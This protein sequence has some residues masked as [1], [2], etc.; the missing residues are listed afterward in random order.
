MSYLYHI[1]SSILPNKRTGWTGWIQLVC[2]RTGNDYVGNSK[3]LQGETKIWIKKYFYH[4]IN[5]DYTTSK[6]KMITEHSSWAWWSNIFIM[7]CGGSIR[8]IAH[9][10]PCNVLF[11]WMSRPVVLLDLNL[12][13]PPVMSFWILELFRLEFLSGAHKKKPG[14]CLPKIWD[15]PWVLSC[16]MNSSPIF[17]KKNIIHISIKNF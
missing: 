13:Y 6:Q 3:G 4:H 2:T 1:S 12:Q 5:Y 9:Y 8:I 14:I 17:N 10:V 11:S 7:A 15:F 16:K